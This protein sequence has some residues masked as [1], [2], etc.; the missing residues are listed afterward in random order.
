MK[1]AVQFILFFFIQLISVS[2]KAQV[3]ADTLK[4]WDLNDCFQY[5]YKHNIQIA[6]SRLNEQSVHQDFLQAKAQ[7][8][9]TLS[10]T[11]GNTFTHAK[12]QDTIS[13][14]S[15]VDQIVSS[16][17][18]TLNSSVILWNDN[19]LRTNV[20]E[21]NLQ[22]QSAGFSVQEIQNSITFSITT[23]YL[24]ALLA[25]ENLKYVADLVNATEALEKQ[26][27]LFYQVGTIAKKDLLQLQAQLASDRY[28]LVQAQ[29]A[30]RQNI[31]NLKQILQ[32]PSEAPFDV[33]VPPSVD[34]DIAEILPPLQQ[35]QQAALL[36]F[37]EVK[38]S[39]LDVNISS[40]EI[41]RL[42]AGL[43]P[44]LSASGALGSNYNSVLTNSFGF[45]GG[46]FTQAG[47]NFYQSIGITL[48]IP[49]FLNRINKT[50]V[51]KAKI[52]YNQSVLNLQNTQLV[53]TQQVEQAYL[54]ASNANQSYKAAQE[55]LTSATE[56]YRI[57]QEQLKIGAVSTVDLLQQRN[58]YVQAV[59][60]YT[61]SKYTALLQQKIY[62]FY[63]GIPITL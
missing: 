14:T 54:S 63:L 35:V 48:S 10:S 60:A 61:Q 45:R 17:I 37:P 38:I 53:L 20:R 19:A 15:L 21:K 42:R 52:S 30:I 18:Y 32:L 23:A 39:K 43:K 26:G 13:R 29:N 58:Q 59:Q 46:Y 7:R 2:L 25:K 24:N 47:N 9:P 6:T 40:L 28:L 8:I 51:E 49:I 3:P 16:G 4:I 36:N 41:A 44:T 57:V 56:S 33:K 50:N 22:A 62:E 11:L 5:A 55:Q 31:L 34:V 12:S 27:E 1:R